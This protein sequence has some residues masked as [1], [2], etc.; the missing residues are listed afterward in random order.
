MIRKNPLIKISFVSSLWAL[1]IGCAVYGHLQRSYKEGDY[2]KEEGAY[3]ASTVTDPAGLIKAHKLVTPTDN[4]YSTQKDYSHGSNMLGD[5]ESTWSSYTGKGTKVAIIDDGFDIDHP[6]YVR[7]DGS[8]AILSTSRYYYT[9]DE[10]VYYKSYSNDPTCIKEEWDSDD[11]KWAT[12]GTNTST[13]AAAPINNGGGVGIAPDA[14]ILALKTDFGFASIKKA[15]QYAVTQKVDVINMSLGAFAETFTDGFGDRQEWSSGIATYLNSVC[16]EAY[17]A[18]VIVVAAAGNEATWHKS[19]PACNSHVIGVGALGKNTE[20]RLAAF[21]NYVSST[22]TGEINVDILAPGHVYTAT[23]GGTQKSISHTYDETQGTSF[24][25]PIVSGAACLWK[26]KYPNG[27]PDEFLAQ[28][29]STAS[30]IG[31]Y[32]SKYV[33]V[34]DYGKK[35]SDVGPSNIECGRLNVSNL[36][37]I[38]DPFINVVQS[39]INLTVGEHKQIDIRT[40][41]GSVTYSTSEAGIATVNN[42]GLVTANAPGDTTLTVTATKNQK[43]AHVDIPVH[44]DDII[45]CTSISVNPSEISIEIG[46]EYEIEPRIATIPQNASR[47]FM[48]ESQNE[49]VASVDE[50]TGLLIATGVGTTT[51]DIVSLY[52]DGE[53]TLTVTVTQPVAPTSFEKIASSNEITNGDYLI[54]YEDGSKAFNGG[55]STLDATNNYIDVSISNNKILYTQGTSSAK[56]TI[57]SLVSGFSI[58][59]ASGYYIGRSANSNGLDTSTSVAYENSISVSNGVAT[60]TGAGGKQL[61]FNTANDQQRF[62]YLTNGSALSLYKA[63]GGEPQEETVPVIGITLSP[64]ELTLD[65]NEI[66]VLTA[67]ISP[68]N[69]SNKNV[70]WTS[71]NES[72]AVVDSGTVTAI[73]AGSATISVITQDGNKIATCAVTVNAPAQ[74][75]SLQVVFKTGAG[76]GTAIANN[77]P[78]SNIIS[79]GSEYIS[80]IESVTSSYCSGTGGLKLGASSAAGELILNLDSSYSVSTVVVNAKLYNSGKMATLSVNGET[81]QTVSS[82]FGDLTFEINDNISSISFLSSKY[83]WISGFTVYTGDTSDK[84]ISSLS[85]VYDGPSIYVDGSLDE[86]KI[87]VHAHFSDPS[88]YNPEL[89]PSSAYQ[90]SGFNSGSAGIKQILV[91][92]IGSLQT[93]TN[94]LT[95]NLEIEVHYDSIVDTSIEVSKIFHPGENVVKGDIALTAIH[96][97]G[98]EEL[99]SDFTFSND[100]YMFTYEDA[101][102]GGSA[103]LKEFELVFNDVTYPFSVSV[104]R[105]AYVAPASS[106][107]SFTGTQFKS[108]GITGTGESGASNY[109]NL[110]VD[111]IIFDLTHAYVFSNQYL[112]FGKTSGQIHNITPLD[113]SITDV[114]L[115]LGNSSRDDAEIYVGKGD[116][117][118]IELANADCSNN[119]YRYF[120]VEYGKTSSSYSNITSI[121]ITYRNADTLSGITNFLMYTDIE[122]QCDNKLDQAIVIFINLSKADREAFMSSNEYAVSTARARLE[123]WMINKGKNIRFENGDYVV[124]NQYI[125]PFDKVSGSDESPWILLAFLL[126]GVVLSVSFISNK[127]RK[128][129]E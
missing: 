93:V 125:A 113:K 23:Q 98:A 39:S 17:N 41:N 8:N 129:E 111:G 67:T 64:T 74:V 96:E 68:S 107:Q 21:T 92:Y 7:S 79:S 2:V 9:S 91:T 87:S 33:P 30:D 43:T 126:G 75:E 86:S 117:N 116:G 18:G 48:Y 38:N 114:T 115:T 6:E 24:S 63:S 123:A 27:T 50:E 28:L 82:S 122:G 120:K 55:L 94:P 60:I 47:I 78:L 81:A 20:G 46:E 108:A 99:R 100:G 95:T 26:E 32:Q 42:S 37:D 54:V 45:A 128:E 70:T 77:T 12:H 36:L 121:N 103:G 51:I 11:N 112:S 110:V 89:L 56:F 15:I 71:S 13:T 127:R 19:Y 61:Q 3:F 52:G 104:S 5:I 59:S 29:Q 35:Y 85:A 102:S 69:A 109:S 31:A 53:A 72:V 10:T 101:P 14:D 25:C 83:I 84:V 49:N 4:K 88:K 44:V 57:N 22:Q 80:S 40:H 97:S 124:S 106:N 118:W 65:V 58:K 66:S 90:L 62:R 34:S 76:D 16:Q 73:G 1:T 105:E 119:D